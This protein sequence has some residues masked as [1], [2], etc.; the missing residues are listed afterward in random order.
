MTKLSSQ[1]SKEDR[2]QMILQILVWCS[3]KLMAMFSAIHL[4]Y[5]PEDPFTDATVDQSAIRLA[6]RDLKD[7]QKKVAFIWV[8][9]LDLHSNI[10]TQQEFFY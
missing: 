2:D 10:D 5:T 1:V 8:T 7:C 9:A 4:F 6:K 3:R